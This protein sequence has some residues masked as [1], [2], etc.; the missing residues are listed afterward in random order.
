MLRFAWPDRVR[1][2]SGS[3]AV[4][5]LFVHDRAGTSL[6]GDCAVREAHSTF[7]LTNGRWGKL[8]VVIPN[9]CDKMTLTGWGGHD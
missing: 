2:V 5:R 6:M 4:G 9:F 1:L 3:E 8:G 7:L